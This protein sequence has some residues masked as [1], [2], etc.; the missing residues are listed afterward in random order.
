[1]HAVAGFDAGHAPALIARVI[2]LF[3]MLEQQLREVLVGG[4]DH[5][6]HAGIPAC[7]QGAADQVI[8]LVLVVGQHGQAERGAQR[9]AVGELAAQ[10]IG[11]GVAVGLVGRVDPVPEAAVQGF[12]EGDGDVGGAFA[13][14]QVEQEAREAVHGIGRPALL[15]LELIGHRMPRAEHVQTGVDQVQRRTQR[16]VRHAGAGGKG[17][18]LSPPSPAAARPGPGARAR[19]PRSSVCRY[20]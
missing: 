16:R 3:V 10:C 13:L 15:I 1:M 2:P 8:G 7:M 9:L 19:E 5:P 14:E 12:I 17:G 18:H 4:D 11:R 20:G 6:A